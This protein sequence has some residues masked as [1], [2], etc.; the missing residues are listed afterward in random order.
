[1]FGYIIAVVNNKGGVG[2]T[3]LTLNLG[4]ALAN[5]NHRVLAIDL[6]NQCNTTNKLTDRSIRDQTLYELL[7]GDTTVEQC[8]Y[9]SQYKNLFCLANH[10][11]VSGIEI[12]LI[13]NRK[14]FLIR[15]IFREYVK[16]N[17][18][19]TIID[20]PPNLLFFVFS[21]LFMTDFV[22]VP[23]LSSSP[24]SLEGLNTVLNKINDISQKENDHLR[25][26]RLL[27][28]N[29][30]RRTSMSKIVVDKLNKTLGKS[31]IFESSI[32]TSAKFTQAEYLGRSI[33]NHAPTSTGAKA[34]RALA[35]EVESLIPT[36]QG[37]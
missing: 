4:H 15:D 21:A 29:V 1:M 16:D 26:L 13:E 5:K 32:P 19:Y 35:H 20:C 25:F 7:L 37:Q 31:Y 36:D 22:I 17:F 2:K 6:D 34:Y 9:Q 10:P 33:L 23:I 18:D 3:T 28:N 11:D 27:I 14:Y 8:I 24:D 12:E 30:D